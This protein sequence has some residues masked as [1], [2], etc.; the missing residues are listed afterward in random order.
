MQTDWKEKLRSFLDA[1]GDVEQRR[2][3]S[4]ARE[5]EQP[6]SWDEV[7]AAYQTNDRMTQQEIEQFLSEIGATIRGDN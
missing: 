6:L 7:V 1:H 3:V 5:T 2:W 4:Y